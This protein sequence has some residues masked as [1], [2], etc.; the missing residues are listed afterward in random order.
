MVLAGIVNCFIS[1]NSIE[2]IFKI[3]SSL[4]FFCAVDGQP[5]KFFFL[6]T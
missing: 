2:Y 3:H 5:W 6:K 4:K 1:I